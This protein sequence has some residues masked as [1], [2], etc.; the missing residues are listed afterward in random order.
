MARILKKGAG[1]RLGWNPDPTCAFQGLVGADDWAVEL[2]AAEFQDFCRLLVQLSET[3][4]SIASELMAEERIS[5]EAESE[6]IW[7]E[8]EGF[9]DSYS[10]RMLV[11]NNRNAEGN[12][13][14]HIVSELVVI[15]QSF[16]KI[17]EFTI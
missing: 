11:L 12:W 14:A 6:L 13:S 1:W 15:A 2:T 9:P 16:Q 8:I 3:V 5:I 7:L 10:L 17:G 4:E